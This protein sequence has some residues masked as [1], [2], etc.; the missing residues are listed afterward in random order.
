MKQVEIGR[1]PSEFEGSALEFAVH[2][3]EVTG[4][5]HFVGRECDSA[6]FLKA[7]KSRKF[8]GRQ[9][10]L[11]VVAAGRAAAILGIG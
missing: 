8:M 1:A 3:V 4:C 10:E 6:P 9:D 5:G 11:A 7:R 2:H